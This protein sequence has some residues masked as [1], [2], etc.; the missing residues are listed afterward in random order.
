MDQVHP[1]LSVGLYQHKASEPAHSL[2]TA[3]LVSTSSNLCSALGWKV[4]G[5]V[6]TCAVKETFEGMIY[7]DFVWT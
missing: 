2:K 3:F 5:S 4:E 7:L 6:W 1:H